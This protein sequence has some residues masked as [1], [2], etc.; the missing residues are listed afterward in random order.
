MLN[1]KRILGPLGVLLV[2]ALFYLGNSGFDWYPFG[3][4]IYS[5][6]QFGYSLSYPGHWSKIAYGESGNRTRKYERLVLYNGD[7]FWWKFNISVQRIDLQDHANDALF[8]FGE[9]LI[10]TEFGASPISKV[11]TIELSNEITAG[12]K[13]ASDNQLFYEIY[14]VEG[15]TGYILRLRSE[16]EYYPEIFP[17]FIDV[18]SSFDASR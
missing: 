6:S 4:K 9:Q 18:A 11:E 15:A 7:Y 12:R 8:G 5:S 17:L 14:F 2:V 16:P 3:P 1:R 13:F 10:M